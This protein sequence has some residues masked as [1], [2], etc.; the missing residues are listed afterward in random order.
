MCSKYNFLYPLFSF[1]NVHLASPK[2]ENTPEGGVTI[3]PVLVTIVSEVIE[4]LN[5]VLAKKVLAVARI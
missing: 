5:S 2:V 3:A 1:C 4:S